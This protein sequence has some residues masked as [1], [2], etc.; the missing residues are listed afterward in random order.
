MAKTIEFEGHEFEYDETAL[1][2]YRTIKA[3]AR[4]SVD[5][6]GFFGAFERVFEGRDEEYADEL[7]GSL[8]KMG[9]LL[10]AIQETEGDEAKN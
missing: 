8:E 5:P 6:A 9:K 3:I 4:G 2:D 10:N 7:D 1:T